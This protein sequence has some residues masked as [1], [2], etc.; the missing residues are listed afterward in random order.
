MNL[1]IKG[2]AHGQWSFLEYV[3]IIIIL[4]LFC[5]YHEQV[6]CKYIARRNMF[7]CVKCTKSGIGHTAVEAFAYC[8]LNHNNNTHTHTLDL[9]ILLL[10]LEHLFLTTHRHSCAYVLFIYNIFTYMLLIEGF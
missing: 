8:A 9:D 10:P 5:L 3:P 1:I 2:S 6:P 4:L 7:M